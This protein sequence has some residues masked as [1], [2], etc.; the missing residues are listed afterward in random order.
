MKKDNVTGNLK[1]KFNII[2][3]ESLTTE[4]I[5]HLEKALS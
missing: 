3:P 5:E 4:Q 2:F 1:V